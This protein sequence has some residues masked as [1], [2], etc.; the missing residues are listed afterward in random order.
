M[1]LDERI[2]CSPHDYFLNRA[3]YPSNT[4]ILSLIDQQILPDILA[5]ENRTEIPRIAI[6]NSGCMRF[7]IF[8]GT[9][10]ER[11]G[12]HYIAI[13]QSV[14]VHKGRAV[15]SGEKALDIAQQWRTSVLECC[16]SGTM[17]S[18]SARANPYPGRRI[19]S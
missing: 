9:F 1:K 13:C 5:G 17:A 14:P 6:V 7:D 3:E 18:C 4:S 12:S 16:G 2:G 15:L 19:S 10:Y 11:Y 8:Q